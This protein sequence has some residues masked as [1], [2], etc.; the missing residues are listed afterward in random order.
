MSCTIVWNRLGW[1]GNLLSSCHSSTMITER[2]GSGIVLATGF[3]E[4]ALKPF[5]FSSY[6]MMPSKVSCRLGP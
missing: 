4:L 2:I 5:P 1:V 6:L 3:E